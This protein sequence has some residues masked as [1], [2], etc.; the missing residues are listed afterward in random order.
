MPRGDSVET[1]AARTQSGETRGGEIT[2][3]GM[4]AVL[5]VRFADGVWRRGRL[6]KRVAGTKPTRW[7]VQ[8]DDG[9]TRADIRG[10]KELPLRFDA[11]GS[12]VEV[13]VDGAW[14]RGRLVELVRVGELWGVAFDDGDWAE[15]VRL[16]SPDVRFVFAGRAESRGRGAA[17]PAE[18]HHPTASG[19]PQVCA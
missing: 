13:R 2:P 15:D 11:Y 19:N 17:S 14:F 16:G 10:S 5:E 6:V 18:H 12:T 4:E 3:T 9:E 7:K 8:Y 1:A